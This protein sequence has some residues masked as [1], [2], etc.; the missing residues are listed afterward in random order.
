MT[1]VDRERRR[2]QEIRQNSSIHGLSRHI[3]DLRLDPQ[4][5]KKILKC[6]LNITVL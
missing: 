2:R 5:Y 3:K 6:I 1:R 4:G